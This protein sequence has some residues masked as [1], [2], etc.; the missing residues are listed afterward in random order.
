MRFTHAA[1]CTGAFPGGA[2]YATQTQSSPSRRKP[3]EVAGFLQTVAGLVGVPVVFAEFGVE[4]KD[5]DARNSTK[6][7]RTSSDVESASQRD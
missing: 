6:A 5:P 4:A 2:D 7:T 3:L 1:Q